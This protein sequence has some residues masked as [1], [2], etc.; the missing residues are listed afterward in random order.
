V[1][2][3]EVQQS[4]I[5]DNLGARSRATDDVVGAIGNFQPEKPEFAEYLTA[6]TNKLFLNTVWQHLGI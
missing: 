6:I 1:G 2:A 5:E 4:W 3:I